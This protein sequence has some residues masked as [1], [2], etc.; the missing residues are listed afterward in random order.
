[1]LSNSLT[2]TVPVIG[3]AEREIVPPLPAGSLEV[4][5]VPAAQRGQ[6]LPLIRI[7]IPI[8]MVAAMI[9][10][11]AML[12][13]GDGKIHPMMLLFP[14]MM[15]A[16]MLMMLSNG[17]GNDI[18]ETRRTYLRHLG[19]L[20]EQ[21]LKNAA[22]QRRHDLHR[23][24]DPG[25]LWTLVGS[26]RMW[27]RATGD[28]DVLEVRCGSGTM[29]LCTPL[30]VRDPGATEDLDPVCAVSLRHT[31]ATVGEVADMPI[32]IQLQAFPYLGLRGTHAADVARALIAQLV[33]HHGPDTVGV[34][35]IGGGWGWLK[36]VP[37]HRDYLHAQHRI[38]VVD[39][40]DT[41]GTEEFL[42]HHDWDCIIDVGT[43]PGTFL[44]DCCEQEGLLIQCEHYL[45]AITET[46]REELGVSDGLDRLQ[47][48]DLARRLSRYDRP[49]G[50]RRTSIPGEEHLGLL[51]LLGITDLKKV[52]WNGLWAPRGSGHLAIPFGVDS[53]G[54]PVFL[55]IKESAKGGMGPHGLC[56]GATGSG[57][58]ETL[59]TLV[60]SL[61][62]THSPA[63]VNLVLVDFKGGAT[64]LGLEKLPHTSAV[65]TN[66]EEEA[67]LVDRMQDAI[68]GEL[69]RRQ[70]ILRKAGNFANISDYNAACP[71]LPGF[72]PI[73]A[74]FIIV[75]EFSELLGHHPDF[76]DLFVAVGRLGRSLNIHL[77]LASQRLEEGKL[78]G[79]DSHLSY[80]IGLKTFSAAES[81]QVIGIPDAHQL[82]GHPGA[83]FLRS[84]ADRITRFQASYVSGPLPQQIREVESPR[85]SVHL[86]DSWEDVTQTQGEMAELERVVLDHSTTVVDAVVECVTAAA[87]QRGETAHQ[88]WL[89]PLPD[90]IELSD[91]AQEA[92]GWNVP[93]GVIDR[94]YFQRQDIFQ[95]DLESGGGHLAVCGGPR[96]GK[97]TLLFSFAVSLAV[98]HGPEDLA[99]YVLD[100][101]GA[102]SK[103]SYLPHVAG[104]AQQ[105]DA[106]RV[107]RMIDEL[108]SRIEGDDSVQPGRRI[109]LLIDGWHVISSDFENLV[110]KISRL[111]ADGPGAGIHVCI[112]T[113]RWTTLRPAIRDLIQHRVE[114]RLSEAMDS[115][116]DRH[117]Q[118]KIPLKPGRGITPSAEQMLI[119]MSSSQDLAYVA[120]TAYKRGCQK[121][122][123]LRML[124]DEVKK[125]DLPS[126]HPKAIPLGV[127]GPRLDTLLWNPQED[128]HIVCTGS[129]GSG[130]STFLAA[131]SAGISQLAAHQARIVMIDHRRSHLG[132]IP[133]NM[134]AGYSASSVESQKLLADTVT[135]LRTRL[136]G[137][138]IT[139]SQLRARDWWEGPDIYLLIDDLDLVSEADLHQLGELLPHSRDIG[140]HLVVARK[141]GG[142]ARAFFSTFLSALK[143]QQPAVLLL[144]ADPEEG[145]IMGIKPQSQPPGRGKWQR[146]GEVWGVCRIVNNCAEAEV[147]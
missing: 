137:A 85:V 108:C 28:P 37:H 27:E 97:S 111:A 55:D 79:L 81:R 56:I 73:P 118:G 22:A 13:L 123:Q 134:L 89:P 92:A 99:F 59:R 11:V 69:N 19:S 133:Q 41:T 115:L 127:G 80:R 48:L 113:S 143:D 7:L 71:E 66:L 103:L 36:W 102:L 47:T 65:I 88:M 90:R 135:T 24:P 21:A 32:V 5:A 140:L 58:S 57:K 100:L 139:P 42:S 12:F 128:A 18:D 129:Q 126:S 62:S 141:S 76:A 54:E 52:D 114:L 53:D 31:I 70:E 138:D 106:E 107:H 40:L 29:E 60:V 116:I 26:R 72:Q 132:A 20:R 30:S 45:S 9:G 142:I 4:E 63:D 68:S 61:V 64:F 50:G 87:H 105:Q 83:G 67:I 131:V 125:A 117:A 144:D 101:A 38:L 82:P 93:L 1:M 147:V 74:L 95:I 75:D 77:L 78:R 14:I 8:V 23:H 49:L 34:H 146:R 145:K 104:I 43:R 35:A 130:K 84:D 109:V 121:V 3:L 94:P 6:K 15:V 96:S 112:S 2:T 10:M 120:E 25:D 124:P 51:G 17:S 110:D 39:H 98:H 122:P 46:G 86:F 136:P 33:F 44:Y 16:S 91:I 119:A